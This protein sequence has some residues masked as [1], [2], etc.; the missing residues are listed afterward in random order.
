MTGVF[1]K[2]TKRQYMIRISSSPKTRDISKDEAKAAI[3]YDLVV[4]N[5]NAVRTVCC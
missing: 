5:S 4:R 1:S 2:N 3:P